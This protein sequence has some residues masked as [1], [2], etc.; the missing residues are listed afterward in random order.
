MKHLLKNFFSFFFFVFS[1]QSYSSFPDEHVL[2]IESNNLST[3]CSEAI[4]MSKSNSTK[5][6]NLKKE[7]LSNVS[8]SANVASKIL[9]K[10]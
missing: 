8:N 7:Y 10:N 3:I 1:L 4:S 6:Q 9:L 2:Y 5:I